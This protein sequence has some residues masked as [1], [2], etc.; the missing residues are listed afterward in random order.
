MARRE[1]TEAERLRRIAILNNRLP[2]KRNIAQGL[3]RNPAGEVLLCELTYKQEWDLPGGVVDPGEPPA[4]T[5]VREVDEEL[6]IDVATAGLIAV[7]WLP[8]WRG[9]DDAHLFLFDLG[10]HSGE[11][12]PARFLRREIVDAHWVDP[13]AV[14]DH[15]APYTARMLAS[16][17]AWTPGETLYLEDGTAPGGAA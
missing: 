3:L 14:G 9:W 6:G 16:V 15:V 12:D 7:N 4:R 13:S 11:L 10:V 1:E 8:P 2:K 17:A 5:V